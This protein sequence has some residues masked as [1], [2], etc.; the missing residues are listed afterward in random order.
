MT[1]GGD[2]TLLDPIFQIFFSLWVAFFKFLFSLGSTFNPI[3][4]GVRD[5]PIIDGGQILQFNSAIWG[6]TT[7]K[8]GRNRV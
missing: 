8:L 1:G 5:T 3:L 6:L 4:D 2:P 7:M